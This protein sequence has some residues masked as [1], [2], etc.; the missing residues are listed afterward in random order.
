VIQWI[1][2]QA[3]FRVYGHVAAVQPADDAVTF[4]LAHVF[5]GGRVIAVSDQHYGVG[6]NLILPGR[7]KDMGDGWETKRSRQKGHNDWAIIQLGAAGKLQTAEIDTAHFLGNFPQSCELHG[8][9]TAGDAPQSGSEMWVPILSR[10]ELGPHRRH[11]FQLETRP[12]DVFS[13]VKVT[14]YPDGGIKR[15]RI[16]GTRAGLAPDEV[17]SRQ[18]LVDTEERTP[19]KIAHGVTKA[20]PVLPLTHEAFAPYGQVIQ[21]YGDHATAPRGTKITPANGGTASK[22]HK[23][24]LLRGSYPEGAGATSGLSVYRCQPVAVENG[25][26]RLGVLERHPYTNQA[27]VPMGGGGGRYLVVVALN[28]RD[29]RADL[30]S[31]KAFVA[32]AGQGVV[33]DTG[34]WHQPMTVLDKAMDFT[35]VETQIGNGDKADCE[36]VELDEAIAL[37]IPE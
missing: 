1:C 15:V 34:I 23:L 32:S 29:D 9:H 4:D 14:I 6:S 2:L 21:A 16:N 13:H 12:E 7:G 19:E 18:G 37:Q 35:C 33:Y 24:A 31:V 25:R 11:S 36:V 17:V 8:C 20:I 26:V 30:G 27:F 3:R 5:A 22:F 10:V 28:G